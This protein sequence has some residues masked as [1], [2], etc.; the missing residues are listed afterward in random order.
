MNKNQKNMK[1][2]SVFNKILQ[3]FIFVFLIVL[4]TISFSGCAQVRAMTITNE[5]DSIDEL[6]TVSLDVNAVLNSGYSVE[7]MKLEIETTSINIATNMKEKLNSKIMQDKILATQETKEI[8]NSFIDGIDVVK[9]TWKENTFAIGIRFKNINIYKYYY[10]ITENI[11]KEMH[12]EKHFFYDKIYYYSSTM[13]VKH[14]ALYNSVNSHFSLLYPDLIN[15][16]TN[17]LLYSYKTSLRRQHSDADFITKQ[18]SEYYHTWVVDPNNLDKPIMLYY[19]VANPE[20]YI[21]VALAITGGAVVVLGIVA[22]VIEVVKR[23]KGTYQ[24]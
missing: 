2:I 7:N 22:G 4:I 16:E 12:T 19:N 18:D 20:S 9:S 13:Y 21:I 3:I 24:S 6:V 15:S 5:D 8:L 10:N 11:K 23:K 1:K 17:E 14:N